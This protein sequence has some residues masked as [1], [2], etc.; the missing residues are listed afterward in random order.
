MQ[1]C[2]PF[3]LAL[4]NHLLAEQRHKVKVVGVPLVDP[5][6]GGGS[7]FRGVIGLGDLAEPGRL[8]QLPV[9]AGGRHGDRAVAGRPAALGGG[10]PGGWVDGEERCAP[11]GAENPPACSQH[12]E[13]GAQSTQHVGVHDRVKGGSGKRRA[14][15]AGPYRGGAGSQRL[16]LG[17][18]RGGPQS[19][20]RH[21]G[22]DHLAA[23][24][25]GQV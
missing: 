14:A 19:L 7:E 24:A 9:R 5:G 20:D 21:I 2:P 11:A 17:A 22:Q 25:C 23:G 15:G 18:G 10:E 1:L 16:A 6:A 8:Q 12:G 4:L 3:G 13:L